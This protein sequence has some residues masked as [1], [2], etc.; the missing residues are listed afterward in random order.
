MG[1]WYI[2]F[3]LFILIATYFYKRNRWS[4][5]AWRAPFLAFGALAVIFFAMHRFDL[6]Q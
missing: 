2:P 3:F 6:Q 5:W 4:G 1:W